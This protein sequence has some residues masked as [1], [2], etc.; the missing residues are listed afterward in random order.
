MDTM[1]AARI[2]KQLVEKGKWGRLYNVVGKGNISLSE[3][4]AIA[5][6][7]LSESG[8]EVQIFNASTS[9]LEAELLVPATEETVKK[10][11]SLKR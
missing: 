6:V 8:K 11:I 10:F 9:R 5:G 2:A 4:A 7:K 3:F 1:D